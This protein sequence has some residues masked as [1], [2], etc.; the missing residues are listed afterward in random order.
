MRSA[1]R[2]PQAA[3]ERSPVHRSTKTLVSAARPMLGL[4]TER[5]HP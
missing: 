4:P 5:N 1:Y 3:Y 2:Y